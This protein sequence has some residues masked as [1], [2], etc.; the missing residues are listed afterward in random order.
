MSVM[1]H[2]DKAPEVGFS[3]KWDPDSARRQFN[4]SLGLI[5]ALAVA[6]S[7]L[8]FSMRPAALAKSPVS[9]FVEQSGPAPYGA[10]TRP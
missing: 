2:F 8:A 5:A 7:V 1:D 10:L 4:V 3:R 6:A 9:H